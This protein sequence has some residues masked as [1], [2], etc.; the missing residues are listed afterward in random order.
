MG[1]ND[2]HTVLEYFSITIRIVLLLMPPH[3]LLH[4]TLEGVG[5]WENDR[6]WEKQFFQDFLKK[7]NVF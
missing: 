3:Y 6:C 7:K 1:C 5:G 4:L 2:E